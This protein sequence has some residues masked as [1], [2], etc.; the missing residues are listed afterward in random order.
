MTMSR[1]LRDHVSSGN[2]GRSPLRET[3][4][5]ARAALCKCAEHLLHTRRIADPIHL[6]AKTWTT[7]CDLVE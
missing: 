5:D 2:G 3:S 1:G 6:E 4:G 7:P